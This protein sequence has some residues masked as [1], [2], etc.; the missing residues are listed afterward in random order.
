MVTESGEGTQMEQAEQVMHCEAS[1]DAIYDK[2][3]LNEPEVMLQ[4]Q[5][6]LDA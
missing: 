2:R 1:V 3:R 4:T 6:I 5:L